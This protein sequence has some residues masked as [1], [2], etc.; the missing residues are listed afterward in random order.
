MGHLHPRIPYDLVIAVDQPSAASNQAIWPP[1]SI[2]CT[3]YRP[4]DHISECLR[5]VEQMVTHRGSGMAAGF[6]HA[7]NPPFRQFRSNTPTITPY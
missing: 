2:Q 5:G 4:H 6:D 7:W 3:I 1:E